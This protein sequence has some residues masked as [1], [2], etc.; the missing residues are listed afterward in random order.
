MSDNKKISTNKGFLKRNFFI[1]VLMA[2]LVLGGAYLYLNSKNLIPNITN[3]KATIEPDIEKKEINPNKELELKVADLEKLILDLASTMQQDQTK[4]SEPKITQPQQNIIEVKDLDAYELLKS[5]NLILL[6]IDNQKIRNINVTKLQSQFMFFTEPRLQSLLSLPDSTF[7]QQQLSKNE[8]RF[9]KDEFL[10]NTKINW[11]KK[12]VENIFQISV[13]KTSSTSVG[14]FILAIENKNYS[15][16]VINYENLTVNQK[17]FF[18]ET[19]EIAK[20]YEE[21]KSF[22][23]N[24]F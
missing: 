22:L 3:V 14:S 13:A 6:N 7:T 23:E 16:A 15:S 5:M 1:I 2:V 8:N 9:I 10:K 19:Y 12:I 18:K 24:L 4:N 20:S 11:F 17:L 21:Q